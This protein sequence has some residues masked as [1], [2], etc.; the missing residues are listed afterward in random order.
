M[1]TPRRVYKI[2]IFCLKAVPAAIL[3]S[4]VIKLSVFSQSYMKILRSVLPKKLLKAAF[5]AEGIDPHGSFLQI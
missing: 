1:G 2:L 5:A 3:I 4:L